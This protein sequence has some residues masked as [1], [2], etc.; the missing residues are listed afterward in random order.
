[1]AERVLIARVRADAGDPETLLVTAPGVGIADGVPRAGLFLNQLDRLTTVK[2]LGVRHVLRLPRDVQ[3]RVVE[4]FIPQ[5]ATP[6]GYDAPLVRIDPRGHAA[7]AGADPSGGAGHGGGGEQAGSDLIKI[8]ATS[9]GIFYR[10]SSPET[11]PFVEVGSLIATG[12]VLGLVEVMKCF[13]PIT[14]G[15]PGLPERGEIVKVLAADAG[16]VQFGQELF[17]VRPTGEG[18]P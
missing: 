5:A 3:G 12:S 7:D 11:P 16:E 13:N 15:G 18:R 14:Y 6:V 10:R 9:E 1:M 17:W 2:I 8:T 4:T